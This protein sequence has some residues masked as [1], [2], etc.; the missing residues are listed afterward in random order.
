MAAAE[1]RSYYVTMDLRAG[2][3]GRAVLLYHVSPILFHPSDVS[4]HHRDSH[5]AVIISLSA[6]GAHCG[7]C[8]PA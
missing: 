2:E 3:R 1:T 8:S 5:V 4:H 7:H 6:H